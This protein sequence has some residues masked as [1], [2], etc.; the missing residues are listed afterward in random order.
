MSGLLTPVSSSLGEQQMLVRSLLSRLPGYTPEWMLAPGAKGYALLEILARYRALLDISAQGLPER[1]LLALLDMLAI[2]LLSAQAARTP[3]VFQLIPNCP[4]DVTVAAD[5]QLAAQPAP[6]PPS[7]LS[8]SLAATSPPDPAPLLFF[9]EQTVTLARAKLAMLYSVDPGSDT[10]SD[11]SA[12][13]VNKFTVFGDMVRTEHAVYLGHDRLF[14]LGGHEITLLLQC[15]FEQHSKKPARTESNEPEVGEET[16]Q[17]PLDIHWQYLSEAGWITLQRADEEDTTRGFTRDGQ[18]ALRL[19]CGPDAK[20]ETF[21][22]RTS[23][24]LRGT[25]K[26]PVIRGEN[27]RHNPI[28]LNDLRIRV[29]FKKKDLLPEAAFAENTRLDVTKDFYPFGQQPTTFNTFYIASNEV[30][31]RGGARVHI[32]VALSKN[33]EPNDSLTLSWQYYSNGG[34]KNLGIEPAADGADPYKF[35]TSYGLSLLD[36]VSADALPNEGRTLVIIALVSAALHIRIFDHKRGRVVDKGESELIGGVLLTNLKQQLNPLPDVSQLSRGKKQ[37]I[38]HDATSILGD[39]P[40]YD[41]AISQRISFNCPSDW[42]ENEVNGT[43]NR[44][45]RVRITEG[46]YSDVAQVPIGNGTV[47]MPVMGNTAAPVVSKLT[48]SYTYITDPESLDHCL[49]R[50]EFQFEDHTEDVRWPNR[51][52]DPFWPVSDQQPA[53]HFGFDQPLPS[54]LVSLY[55]Q[56]P[57]AEELEPGTASAFTWEY[58]SRSGW[59]QLG[60]RDETNG[61]RQSGMLQF[62]GPSDAISAPGLSGNSYRIR[63]RLKDGVDRIEL[64]VSGLWLNSVWASHRV[65]IEQ[66]LLGTADGTPRQALRF[67]HNPVLVDEKVEIREWAG[68]GEGWQLVAREVPEADLRYERDPNNQQITAAWVCWHQR[69]HLHDAKPSDR[70][71]VLE[72]ATGLI[73][74]GDGT[75]GMIPPAGSRIVATYLTGGGLAGNMQPGTI[76]QLRSAVPFVASVTNPIAVVGGADGEPV[77]AIR[78]RGPQHLRHRDRAVTVSDIEWIAR[79]ASPEVARARCLAITGPAG[80]AQRGWITVIIVPQSNADRPWPSAELQRRVAEYL[81]TRVPA[82]IVRRLRVVEPSYVAL[83]VAA[84]IV[85]KQP[86]AA[87]QVEAQLRANLNRFLHPLTGGLNQKGWDFGEDAHL[88]NIAAVIESTEG[89]DFARD[90]RL[91]VEGG[92][93]CQSVAV[94]RDA[95]LCSGAHELKL[96]V[97]GR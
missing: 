93:H 64:P 66:E 60:V 40:N 4:T 7:P 15:T 76:T 78:D 9:T 26:S 96:T 65:R 51:S 10:Y 5:S 61:L 13:L 49:S 41:T 95:L 39:T 84:E 69:A 28:T 22:E 80:H 38:I 92:E 89:V 82:S 52:F 85:P 24:W 87:A 21:H 56:V 25:L 47:N 79:D 3:L 91:Y 94:P 29:Q 50:N 83:N 16:P 68:N 71:Y 45:L 44:W 74:F 19:N 53:L 72:R 59:L 27:L 77:A 14:K 90:I 58:L 88:S 32:D 97:G 70:A 86:G 36:V 48:L 35:G 34:W 55:V 2:P 63:A 30:F 67:V 1:N 42:Q 81:R 18:I 20:K 57:G 75:Q 62:I 23:Y 37:K 33:G 43:K 6:L 46:S 17:K 12:S 31:Q 73:R 54:G 11:H 8:L